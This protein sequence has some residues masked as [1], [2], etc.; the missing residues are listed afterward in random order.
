LAL[1]ILKLPPE[2]EPEQLPIEPFAVSTDFTFVEV[3]SFGSEE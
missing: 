1:T 3:P 2:T